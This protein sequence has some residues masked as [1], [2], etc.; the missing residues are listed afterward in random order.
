M[1]LRTI[2]LCMCLIILMFGIMLKYTTWRDTEYLHQ[3]EV[4][5]RVETFDS[6]N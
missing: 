1:R 3:D 6:I 4:V 5:E 2:G